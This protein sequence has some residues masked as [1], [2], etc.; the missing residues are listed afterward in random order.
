[1]FGSAKTLA[2]WSF[3]E[4]AGTSTAADVLGDGADGT[5]VDLDPQQAWVAGRKGGGA[6]RIVPSAGRPAPGVRIDAPRLKALKTFTIAAW[7]LRASTTA[8][9]VSVI[10]QQLGT[11]NDEV[12]NLGTINDALN[13]YLPTTT[14]GSEHRLRSNRD[15]PIGVWTHVAATF[16][17]T[18]ARLY[19]NGAEVGS[20]AYAR[21][22]PTSTAPVFIGLNVNAT[23]TQPLYGDVDA[24]A[25]FDDALSPTD[26]AKLAAP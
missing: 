22:L 16:D 7:V 15:V 23:N 2:V 18:T 13:L 19:F 21:A 3:D 12:F 9:Q 24:V 26:L 25:I 10:S 6:L 14:D 11:G 1:M 4:G 20:L 5:L 8:T 17:G